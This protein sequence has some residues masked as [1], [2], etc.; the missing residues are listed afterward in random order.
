[1]IKNKKGA[2]LSMNVIIISIL[3]IV[4][5]VIILLVFTGQMGSFVSK[6]KTLFGSQGV[7]LNT[8]IITC[9]GLCQSYSTSGINSYANDFCGGKK[10]SIDKN[11]DGKI[12]DTEKDQTCN[13]HLSVSCSAIEE[14]GGCIEKFSS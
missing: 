6:L 1:M 8:A 11:G 3:V 4:V 12:V 2:E 9:N 14:E 5:L 7:D 13:E 10:F